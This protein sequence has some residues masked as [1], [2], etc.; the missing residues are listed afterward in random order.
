VDDYKGKLL[1]K[2]KAKCSEVNQEL[3]EVNDI[4]EQSVSP[5]CLEVS[6]YCKENSL[7]NPLDKLKEEKK[8]EEKETMSSEFKSLY[9]QIAIQTHPDKGEDDVKIEKY[10]QA[11]EAKK[12]SKID[13]LVSIAKDLKINLNQMSFSDIKTIE[14]SI[15]DTE[16]MISQVRNS[17]VWA[18]AMAANNKREDIIFKFV[19]NNV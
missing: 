3:L 10:Q 12:E 4:Y 14:N 6:S 1:R 7:E 16:K 18:W 13:K 5:F 19:M 9:R 15:I 2:L 11:T 8:E 17:Y